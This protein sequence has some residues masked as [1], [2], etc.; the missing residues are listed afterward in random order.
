MKKLV[1]LVFTTG[2]FFTASAQIQFGVKAGAN[3][4]TLSGPGSEGA[5]TKVDFHGGGFARIPLVN[6]FF[7]QPE[8]VYSRARREGNIGR[9]C[10]QHQSILSE[11]SGA[12]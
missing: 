6:S 10:F 11:Y 7:L 2:V 4:A 3:F 8:L 12:R 9:D 5:T 1:F